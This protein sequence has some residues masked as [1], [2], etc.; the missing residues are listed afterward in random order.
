MYVVN[1]QSRII[2]AQ[3]DYIE[4]L[5]ALAETSS[6]A[7]EVVAASSCIPPTT[8]ATANYSSAFDDEEEDS[9]GHDLVWKEVQFD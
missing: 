5:K 1:R 7:E 6:L 2:K 4:C 3:D 8:T 9:L